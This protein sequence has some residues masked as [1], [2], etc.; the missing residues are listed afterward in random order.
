MLARLTEAEIAADAYLAAWLHKNSRSQ[1]QE[2]PRAKI[3]G[4]QIRIFNDVFDITVG[5]EEIRL[6]TENIRK[7][8]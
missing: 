6:M 8:P 1:L 7:L 3:K 5:V 2:A 4:D